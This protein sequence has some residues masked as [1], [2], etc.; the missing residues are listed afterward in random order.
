M[1][2]YSVNIQEVHVKTVVVEANNET[3]ARDK[4][5]KMISSDEFDYSDLAYSH[6]VD[7]NEWPVYLIP[8]QEDIEIGEN[9]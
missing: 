3:E 8:E 5:E 7:R 1:R 2:T 6:H 9:H 4:A